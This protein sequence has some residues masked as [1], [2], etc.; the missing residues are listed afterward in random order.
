MVE[1]PDHQLFRGRAH[2]PARRLRRQHAAPQH[3]RISIG[4]ADT[5]RQECALR[6][7]PAVAARGDRA[8]RICVLIQ[9]QAR[10]RF[11]QRHRGLD[12]MHRMATLLTI[13][14]LMACFALRF[15]ATAQTV[16]LTPARPKSA[17]GHKVPMRHD[18]LTL[19]PHGRPRAA[20][21]G[22][23]LHAPPV[24]SANPDPQYLHGRAEMRSIRRLPEVPDLRARY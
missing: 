16:S 11:S 20:P 18:Q 3:R 14:A 10:R 2:R 17:Q 4:S 24:R 12:K 13:V 23:W 5:R 22:V 6:G 19:H 21:T 15:A 7:H 9:A 8:R 1:R